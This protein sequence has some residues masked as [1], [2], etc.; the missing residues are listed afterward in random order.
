MI[1]LFGAVLFLFRP[2]LF[3]FA[4][5]PGVSAL[6]SKFVVPY[7]FVLCLLGSAWFLGKGCGIKAW[8]PVAFVV[9]VELVYVVILHFGAG[10]L[11]EKAKLSAWLSHF[12]GVAI[13]HRSMI[14]FQGDA[15]QYDPEL[16]YTLKPGT[17]LFKSFEFSTPY[18]VNSLGVRDDEQSADRP[19]VVFLGDS[20]TM[21]WGVQQEEAFAS[22]F[23][24]RTGVKS[25]NTGVS[26]YGT[27]RERF[28]LSRV[29]LDSLKAIVLQFHDT[30][31]EENAYY[32][33][34]RRLGSRTQGEFDA[35]VEDNKKYQSYQPF[36]YLKTALINRLLKA[37]G[38]TEA[39]LTAG[40]RPEY[41]GDFYRILSEIKAQKDVPIF[42]TYTGS[43][44][45]DPARVAL[46]E[47]YAT[48][49]GIQGV[50]FINAGKVLD[51][52][53]YFYFDDHLNAKGHEKLAK[54]LADRYKEVIK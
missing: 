24:K 15:A 12:K 1:L 27:A 18:A 17:S 32:L 33:K 8:I 19:E 2:E 49:N 51:H 25:L 42:F 20:F 53:D 21:G 30:D 43:F 37:N 46:F 50:Y 31:P 48:E 6:F 13:N 14:Q 44:Y 23:E 54:L 38:G 22:R 28:M 11:P 5:R 7:G 3:H 47:A 41:I 16:F 34:E 40:G 45:T 35:Q 52:E 39:A 4:N 9:G 10:F 36:Q 26:S 29:N